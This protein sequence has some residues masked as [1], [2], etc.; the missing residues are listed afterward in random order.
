MG[1]RNHSNA[2]GNMMAEEEPLLTSPP[3]QDAA[4]H[5]RDYARFTKLMTRGAIV[6]LIV[7]FIVLLVI[8]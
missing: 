8:Q 7:G 6:C 5:V 1:L 4:V 3:T 2:K